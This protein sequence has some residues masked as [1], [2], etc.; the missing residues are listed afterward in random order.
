MPTNLGQLPSNQP[1]P[2]GRCQIKTGQA[3]T[4]W[5]VG[6]AQLGQ[7]V[8]DGAGGNIQI[9]FTP[10]RRC[11]WLVRA[12]LITAGYQGAWQRMDFGICITPADLNGLTT[13]STVIS[14][15]YD[16]TTVNWTGYSGAY[17]FLLEANIAYVAWLQFQYSSGGIQQ[18]YLGRDYARIIGVSKSEGI[19]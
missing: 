8:P 17:P 10:T 5:Y 11:Y 3:D 19:L 4:I 12:N 13:G 16:S 7:A 1:I 14:D 2:N 9:A 6:P 15:C 18:I